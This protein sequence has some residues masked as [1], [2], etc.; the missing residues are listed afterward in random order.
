LPSLWFVAAR[1]HPPPLASTAKQKTHGD[2]EDLWGQQIVEVF[3]ADENLA[4]NPPAG[5]K[6]AGI[7]FGADINPLKN[8]RYPW[9]EAVHVSGSSPLPKRRN[10]SFGTRL[11][12]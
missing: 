10:F 7:D 12:T 1:S 5:S 3:H 6:F 9:K 2:A 11:T 4:A 8:I